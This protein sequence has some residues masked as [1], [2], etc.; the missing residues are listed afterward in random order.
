[1]QYVLQ[2]LWRTWNGIVLCPDPPTP[3]ETVEK[4]SGNTHNTLL[5]P[6]G[7]QS[8]TQDPGAIIEC[9]FYASHVAVRH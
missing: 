3:L 4:G 8:V 7:I 5:C 2:L 1:M 6:R 9:Q